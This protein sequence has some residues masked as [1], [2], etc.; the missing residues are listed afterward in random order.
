MTLFITRIEIVQYTLESNP[1]IRPTHVDTMLS[2]QHP[3]NNSVYY[4]VLVCLLNEVRD[5]TI[6]ADPNQS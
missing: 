6:G 2:I 4:L 1:T 5:A 3:V